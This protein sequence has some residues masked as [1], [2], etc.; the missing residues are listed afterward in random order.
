MD[1]E[2]VQ[3]SLDLER[4]QGSFDKIANTTPISFISEREERKMY[5]LIRDM[6]KI[7]LPY[8]Y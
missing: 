8:F 3:N 1:I 7:Y 2:R 6:L 5:K 4:V